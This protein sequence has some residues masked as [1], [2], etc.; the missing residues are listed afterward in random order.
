MG[1][2]EKFRQLYMTPGDLDD[3]AH[4]YQAGIFGLQVNARPGIGPRAAARAHAAHLDSMQ[5]WFRTK[6]PLGIPSLFFD[7][8][9]HGL[10]R[11]GA[12]VFPQAIGLAATF[13]T[14]LVARVHEAAARETRSRGIRMVLS[15]VIN[16]AT[17]VRWGRT[18][19]TLGEDPWLTSAMGRA[20]VRAFEQAGIVATPK[21][22]VANVGTGGRDSYPVEASTRE[23][24]ERHFPPFKSTIQETGARSVMTAYNSVDGD[25]ATQSHYLLTTVLRDQWKFPGFVI[26]DA[27]ATGGA[28]VLHRT[29]R[30]SSE[31]GA[32][33][34]KSGLDV[35]FQSTFEQ[36]RPYWRAFEQS[37][38]PMPVIDSA[39]ARVLRVKFALGLFD[40]APIN[41]DSAAY[42]NGHASHRALAREAAAASIVLLRNT[43]RRQTAPVLPLASTVRRLA[44]IG[45]DADSV[46]LGGYSGPGIAPVSLR[47]ALKARVGLTVNYA[48]GPGRLAQALTPV[49]ATALTHNGAPGLEAQYWNN[50]DMRGAP[51]L[52][53]V[54]PAIDFTWTLSSPG[55]G[56]PYDWYS[57]RWTGSMTVPAGG[58]R[59][60]AIEGADGARIWVDD[61]LVLDR[62]EKRS[63]GVWRA[64]VTLAAGK[65]ALRVEFHERRGN[66]KFKL[67]WEAGPPLPTE[68]RIAA[69]VAAARASEAAVVVVGVEEGEFRDRSILALPGAQER[70]IRSVAATGVPTVVVIVGGSAVTMPWLDQVDAV[71]MAWYPGEEGGPAMADVLFGDVNP[72]GRLPITFPQREGQLPLTYDHKPTGRG[73]DYLDGSGA[74]LFPFG[75]GLSYTT[76]AWD[77]MEVVRD[78]PSS[79]HVRVLLRNTGKRAGHEVVQLYIRDELT[80][81]SQPLI[82][83]KATTRAFLE[84]GASRWA[85]MTLPDSALALLDR[86]LK[87]V[88]EPG[89]FRL[90][91]GASST[92]IR[93]RRVI[94]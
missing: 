74:P 18:E 85:D 60:L 4:D 46:R 43:P 11:E 15:P 49:P 80:S 64:P 45:V 6:T 40:D 26:S 37:L 88:V 48:A 2:L 35:V 94:Q 23:L 71:L 22:F 27:A 28:T 20:H 52:T 76:F 73:D 65:H 70:L 67:S 47:S 75:H 93:Q 21:H 90:M 25:P 81:V 54:D 32:H 84:P 89:S 31:A 10:M 63:A 66:V 61:R 34:W 79:R 51:T 91:L 82:A 92:D 59:A 19:E 38:V 62:W 30:N 83:L 7:E 16:I 1:P 44:L 58:A 29:E 87:W 14:A 77:S 53:R 13:D 5:Q 36:Q 12:T 86:D 42:W 68:R 41:P 69:A 78:T 3:P 8:A 56:V 72:S 17:D 24:M 50:P 9:L 57:A 33:A 39:V 55:A